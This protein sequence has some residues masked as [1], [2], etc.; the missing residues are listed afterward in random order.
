MQPVGRLVAQAIDD[1]GGVFRRHVA[2]VAVV[3]RDQRPHA[4]QAETAD[5][6]DLADALHA[7]RFN[8]LLKR[9][10]DLVAA[11][12]EAARRYAHTDV[13]LESGLF[14]PFLGSELE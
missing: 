4:A 7:A 2:A 8:F 14:F 11:R 10:L 13:V 6:F 1:V 12:G 9:D 3:H 5:A